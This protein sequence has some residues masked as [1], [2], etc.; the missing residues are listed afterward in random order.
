MYLPME[1]QIAYFG[2]REDSRADN[3]HG[4][5]IVFIDD[6]QFEIA[7]RSKKDAIE[8]ATRAYLQ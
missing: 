6:Q 1:K 8:I 3:G 2:R 7:A 5:H 4:I